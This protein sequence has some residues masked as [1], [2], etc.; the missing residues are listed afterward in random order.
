MNANQ[1]K[2]WFIDFDG[3]LVL[4][5]SHMSN[6]DFI[7]SSTKDFFTKVVREDDY[8]IITTARSHEDKTRIEKFLIKHNIKWNLILCGLPTGSRILINDRKPDGT[9][10]A[11]AHNLNR[12][13]G[14]DLS[15]F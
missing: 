5:K 3:T 14:I 2:T 8:V 10:T 4:H 11:Y 13:E 15:I 9:P 6:N 12:D 7:L 1:P